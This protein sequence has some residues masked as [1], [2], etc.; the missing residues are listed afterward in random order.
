[1]AEGLLRHRLDALGV[2]ARVH[3]AGLLFTD[4]AASP[5]AVEVMAAQGID[6]AGHRSTKIATD[7]VATADLVIGLTREHVREVALLAPD[8]L[9]KTF[10]LKELVRRGQAF[11]PRA[12]GEPLPSWL[13]AIAA[14]RDRVDILG[15]S[16]VDDVDDPIGRPRRVYEGTRA[17]LAGLVERLVALVFAADVD[18]APARESA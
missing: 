4:R 7:L 12:A 15:S 8:A 2:G 9:A 14:D 10:T 11:G 3:S 13:A 1:M 16:D 17:E 5:E 6:I 18:E